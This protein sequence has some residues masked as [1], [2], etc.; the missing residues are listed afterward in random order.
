MIYNPGAFHP[1]GAVTP[2]LLVCTVLPRPAWLYYQ[3]TCFAH[4]LNQRRQ[5]KGG[6][7]KGEVICRKREGKES[8][9]ERGRPRDLIEHLWTVKEKQL[10]HG[11]IRPETSSDHV[12]GGIIPNAWNA[13]A[14]FKGRQAVEK[15]APDIF[16]LA[17]HIE[18][19]QALV[20]L[21][22][23]HFGKP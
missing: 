22:V 6:I 20:V 23:F 4:F 2:V 17:V 19:C 13:F 11:I 7:G 16:S 21:S 12:W 5:A 1:I 10:L 14:G 18:P 3:L 8:G 15:R 9:R